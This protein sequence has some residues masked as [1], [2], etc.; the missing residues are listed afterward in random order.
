MVKTLYVFWEDSCVATLWRES[1]E[2]FLQYTPEW[3]KNT[4][5]AISVSLP[6]QEEPH[7]GD[8][9]RFFFAN[10]LPEGT[11]RTA[12]TQKLGISEQ[13]DFGL[14]EAIGGDCAGALSL[15]TTQNP[16]IHPGKY[17]PL[18]E[19]DLDKFL[20]EMTTKP[21][22][23]AKGLRLSLAGAQQKLPVFRDKNGQLSLPE[24]GAATNTILKPPNQHIEEIALNEYFCMRLAKQIG[25]PVPEVFLIY[26]IERPY[27]MILAIDRYDRYD[28]IEKTDSTLHRIHQEDFCQVLGISPNEKYEAEGGPSL[29]KIADAIDTFSVQPAVDKGLFASWALFNYL[30]GNA[31]AHG[32]N[33]SFLYSETGIRLAP[34]YDLLST[35]IYRNLNKN[36][37]MKIGGEKRLDYV[38]RRH[39]VKFASEID[40]KTTYIEKLLSDNSYYIVTIA[41]SLQNRL[42]VDLRLNNQQKETIEKIV[43]VIK[44]QAAKLAIP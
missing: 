10:I 41:E 35:R 3:L 44:K 20:D 24:E 17:K 23:M 25:L 31:D 34:F 38:R 37:A 28:H 36:M 21:L 39:W 42:A 2:W 1:S 30:I 13:N 16:T 27:R 4:P 7:K 6:L 29:K 32:K 26:D 9:V 11:I 8:K 5:Q 40:I 12:I 14:L 22:I 18:S 15:Y 43:G 33:I 19:E